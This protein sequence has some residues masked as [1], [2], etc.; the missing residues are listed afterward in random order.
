MVP[1]FGTFSIVAHEPDT[2]SWGV[3]VQSKFIAVGSAVPWARAGV[4]A[5]AT[6]A[7]ANLSWGL[8]GLALL[9]EGLNA[10]EVVRR[11]VAADPERDTRQLGV[12]DAKGDS[13]AF[14]GSKCLDWAGHEV[15]TGFACQGNILFGS[16]VV[17]GMARAYEST[18]GDIADRLLAALAAGQREGGDR[19]GQ[20][21]AAL[22]IVRE[23]AGY[24]GGNDR[25]V[26]IRV[27]DHPA[28][29]EELRRIFRVYDLIMLNREDPKSLLPI[30][31]EVALGV[32]HDLAI[33]GY[34]SGRLTGT[35]DPTG[36]AAYT[37]FLSEHNFESK[38]RGDDTIWPSVRAYL[39]ERADVEVARRTGT[40]PIVSDALSRG[41][42]GQP[43]Q[44]G[45]ESPTGPKK[46]KASK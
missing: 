14:T 17:R 23:G 37:R 13:A 20:Q 6:Q 32:Q 4:G 1:R 30:K 2:K 3:A 18:P 5:I 45:G 40:A 38:Q 36:R 31:G 26:D 46:A 9:K 43:K 25:W 11:L 28:P 15:G 41:P 19:R 21:A 44:G 33:L 7:A 22:L 16:A 8:E 27:D 24:L 42:G 10:A 39:K 12:V 29:I 34:Y 35:W